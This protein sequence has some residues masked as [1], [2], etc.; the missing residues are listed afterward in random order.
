[1]KKQIQKNVYYYLNIVTN[2]PEKII[3]ADVAD[4]CQEAA[5]LAV[6]NNRYVILTKDFEK[7]YKNTIKKEKERLHFINKIKNTKN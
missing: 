1:M 7:A 3:A 4:I 5:L 6:R 2:R